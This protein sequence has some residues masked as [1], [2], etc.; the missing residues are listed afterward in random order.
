MES[1]KKISFID[2]ITQLPVLK[3]ISRVAITTDKKVYAVGGFVRD[4]ILNRERNDI[5]I[6]VIGSGVELAEKVANELN[7]VDVSFFK[8]FGTAHFEYDNM[9]IEFVGARKE[10]YDRKTRK[11]IVEDGTFEDDIARR[12][13]TI[14]TI[15]ISLNKDGLWKYH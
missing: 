14:N 10:S 11:P 4:I 9:N 15:A 7:V 3:T 5:D 2:E 1:K 12:D 6:L 13:F 8:N